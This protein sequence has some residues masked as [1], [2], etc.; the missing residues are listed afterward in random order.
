VPD[1]SR[2]ALDIEDL[3]RMARRRLPKS[4]F[5]F[6]DRGS[7]D[8]VALR[9]NRTAL[10][11]I[12]LQTRV[13]NDVSQRDLATTLLGTPLK[14]PLVIGPTGPAGYV[15]YRGE[16]AL[17]RA[18]ARAGIPFTLAST[19]NTA[20]E[21]VL[22][23]GGGSQW[24]QF[25]V[26]RD[27]ETS[28]KSALRAREAGFDALVLTV[29]SIVNYVRKWDARNGATFPVRFTPRNMT[30]ALRHPRWLIGTMGRYMQ[31]EGGLPRY[32]NIPAL[33]GVA[34]AQ[35][36]RHLVKNDTMTWDF[37]RRLRDLWPRKLI[38]KGILHPDDAVMAADCGCDAVIVSNHGGIANDSAPAPIEV[39]PAVTAAVKKRIAVIVDSGFRR[40]SDVLK[41]LALGADAVM[42]GRATLYGA[43][44]AGEE[45]AMRALEILDAE[46][47][48]TMGAIGCTTIGS[49]T[50]D[51]VL[52]PSEAAYAERYRA[53]N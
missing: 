30:D 16:I 45:G 39:L 26:W 12:K 34:L 42:V 13:L 18:A 17:A 23:D 41:G 31:A 36:R 11:R 22:K 32:P 19:S 25:Y 21:S 1:L 52:L 9:H 53:A 7:E 2:A 47:R 43:A 29:D 48:R 40:G 20:M 4:L 50:R 28:M 6:I 35:S 38:V 37:L 46:I 5:D 8:E 15:W 44:A 14:L 3:R 33:D 24:Y 27:L 49:V 51:L 10:E